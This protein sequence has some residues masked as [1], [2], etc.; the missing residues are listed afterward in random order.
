MFVSH[1]MTKKVITLSPDDSISDAARITKEKGIKHIPVVKGGKLK[2]I[3]S[4]R[5]IKEYVLSKASSLDVYELHSLLTKTRVKEI[6][7]TKIF[8]TTPDTPI[9]EA[10][11]IMHDNNIG[12]LPVIERNELAGIVSDRDMFEVLVDITGVRHRGHRIYLT[13][14]D[15]RGSIKDVTDIIRKHGFNLHSILS[16]YESVKKGFRNII[17]RVG[18]SG[19][20]KALHAELEATYIG[21]KI[22]K[23]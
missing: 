20:F 17:V 12:C 3:L 6:M 7:K 10:A 9:E 23:G 15:R 11:M 8:T 22:R 5:E 21:V 16:S 1:W 4:D 13:L 18:G 2:G 14:E 19:N